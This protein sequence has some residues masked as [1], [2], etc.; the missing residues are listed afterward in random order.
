MSDTANDKLIGIASY[1]KG[2]QEELLNIPVSLIDQDAIYVDSVSGEMWTGIQ[3]VNILSNG[4]APQ[5][6][7]ED[8]RSAVWLIS[9]YKKGTLVFENNEYYKALHINI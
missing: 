8:P 9:S 2:T 3:L 1:Y 5:D 7:P 6:D 4:G